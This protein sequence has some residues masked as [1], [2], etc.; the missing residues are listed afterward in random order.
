MLLV[1]MAAVSSLV[2]LDVLDLLNN[3]RRTRPRIGPV[4]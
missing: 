1:A 4:V 2:V 3:R